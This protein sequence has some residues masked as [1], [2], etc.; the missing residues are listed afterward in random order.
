MKSFVFL[1]FFQSFLFQ[2]TSMQ[3]FYAQANH[4]TWAY[5]L[6]TSMQKIYAQPQLEK[7]K[8]TKFKLTQIYLDQI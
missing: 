1:E 4:A 2:N 8:F 5:Q 6:Q 3:N 7:F